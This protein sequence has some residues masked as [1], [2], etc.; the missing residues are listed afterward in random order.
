MSPE[1]DDGALAHAPNTIPTV[2]GVLR[3]A[4]LYTLDDNPPPEATAAV[5]T[6]L[7][8]LVI[9]P[10]EAP[11]LVPPPTRPMQV[12]RELVSDLYETKTGLVL[13]D[14]RGGPS[15]ERTW[16]AGPGGSPRGTRRRRRT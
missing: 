13:H 14:Y 4:G 3:A 5:L 10:V 1:A 11:R 8:E 15:Y 16:R 7:R 6:R 2:R 12:A 9:Q